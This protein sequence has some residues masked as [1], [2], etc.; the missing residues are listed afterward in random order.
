V[1]GLYMG[2]V[3]RHEDNVSQVTRLDDA[4]LFRKTE[5]LRAAAGCNVQ[6]HIYGH[7]LG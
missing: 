6:D 1:Q 7:Y 5:D 4:E 2:A 3:H